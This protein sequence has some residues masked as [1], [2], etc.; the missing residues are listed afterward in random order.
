MNNQKPGRPGFFIV[1]YFDEIRIIMAKNTI[2]VRSQEKLKEV[3][4]SYLV[5]GD[6]EFNFLKIDEP[7]EFKDK[8]I[9]GI[10]F[11]DSHIENLVF[12][13]GVCNIVNFQNCILE[14]ITIYHTQI[15]SLRI[16]SCKI[17]S[18]RINFGEKL[19]SLKNCQI[20]SS[21]IQYIDIESL[22]KLHV[23]KN[24]LIHRLR[25]RNANNS[26]ISAENINHLVIDFCK[27]IQLTNAN[28]EDL[29]IL[30]SESL[31]GTL[32][33]SN[34]RS[35]TTKHSDFRRV[36]VSNSDF[37]TIGKFDILS[38]DYDGIKINELVYP[39]Q[40]I[41]RNTHRLL[42]RIA[43]QNND[44]INAKLQGIQELICYR[45]ELWKEKNFFSWFPLWA[46]YLTNKN[47]SSIK[48]AL[49]S[50]VLASLIFFVA[51]S[52]FYSLTFLDQLLSGRF[53]IFSLNPTHALESVFPNVEK[54]RF[55]PVILSL[56]YIGRVVVGFMLFQVISA[57][58]FFFKNN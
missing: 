31:S 44:L 21:E 10:S 22:N 48:R 23:S 19:F 5:Y 2:G 24:R 8:T 32:E 46:G 18:V 14:E 38:S 39:K 40:L 37:N 17:K 33:L 50:W 52:A 53:F 49:I 16:D 47:G 51:T 12:Q 56:D 58:R 45:E 13:N 55:E 36:V 42:K 3:V 15:S 57:F 25:I 27:K 28:L 11:T 30:E 43:I 20:S 4:P 7:I 29:S 9:S 34:I 1:L 35:F 6:K 26:I 41:N 54:E